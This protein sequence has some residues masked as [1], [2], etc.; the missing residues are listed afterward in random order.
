MARKIN[1]D[2]PVTE[3][4]EDARGRPATRAPSSRA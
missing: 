4:G 1:F 3:P 2:A